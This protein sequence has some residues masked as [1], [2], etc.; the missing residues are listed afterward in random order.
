[1]KRISI[2]RKTA[3]T[4]IANWQSMLMEGFM[5]FLYIMKKTDQNNKIDAHVAAIFIFGNKQR[6]WENPS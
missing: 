3:Q 4:E 2:S 6:T 1:M 5:T